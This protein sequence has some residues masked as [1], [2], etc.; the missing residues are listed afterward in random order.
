MLNNDEYELNLFDRIE[1]ITLCKYIFHTKG[2]NAK[3]YGNLFIPNIEDSDIDW[4]KTN[5]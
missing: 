5:N 3:R 2:S 1:V 4:Q